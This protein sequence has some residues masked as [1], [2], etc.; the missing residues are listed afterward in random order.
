[1]KLK[2]CSSLIAISMAMASFVGS[3]SAANVTET[4]P[5]YALTTVGEL[6]DWT[7]YEGL[8]ADYDW[9]EYEAEY[10]ADYKT[11]IVDVKLTGAAYSTEV[12]G[13]KSKK[14]SGTSII[15]AK[16]NAT[17]SSDGSYEDDYVYGIASALASYTGGTPSASGIQANYT[18]TAALSPN[19][20]AGSKTIT[21]T[22]SS[23]AVYQLIVTVDASKPVTVTVGGEVYFDEFT[24]D[25]AGSGTASKVVPKAGTITL[26]PVEGKEDFE[27]GEK[28]DL[29]TITTD[30][31]TEVNGYVWAGNVLNNVDTA[32]YDYVAK[33]TS[34]D[35][36]EPKERTLNLAAAV[37]EAESI[38][39]D[40]VLRFKD[41][42][43]EGVAFDVYKVEK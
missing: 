11:Y 42:V 20:A 2:I 29:I 22:D 13:S 9:S 19:K 30:Y 18:G 33:F 17:F 35:G 12:T 34:T 43:K 1:M 37:E 3:V 16:I 7:G 38:T 32:A 23:D 31:G 4:N 36:S 28:S 27:V 5:A 10:N 6:T 39:F 40:A 24:D 21:A 14:L 15:G 41:A 26:P 25:V 8:K